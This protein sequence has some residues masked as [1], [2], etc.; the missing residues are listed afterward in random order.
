MCYARLHRSIRSQIAAKWDRFPA[1]TLN[2]STVVIVGVG[3]IAATL[4]P[5]CRAF[6]MK[7]VGVSSSPRTVEGFDMIVARQELESAVRD[8]DFLVLLTPYT[9]ETRHI[10]NARVLAA[11]KPG[12]FLVN[13]ARGG[14]IDEAALIE[15]MQRGHLAGA[16]L[17]VFQTEP[18][19]AD[20]PFWSMPNVI[21]TAHLGGLFDRYTDHAL[22]I[23][24]EN[25]GYFLSR[26]T[27][28]MKNVVRKP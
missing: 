2:D 21:V 9:D 13:V 5:R 10:V 11:M 25:L 18:L 8:A 4:A 22:P 6:G 17:D 26:A 16:A 15:A 19:P 14:V 3:G 1:R 23:L 28:K 12:G 27:G 7:V 24:C 20:H